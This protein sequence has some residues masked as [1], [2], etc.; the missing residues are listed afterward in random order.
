MLKRHLTH[1]V[2]IKAPAKEP[3]VAVVTVRWDLD[4]KRPALIRSYDKPTSGMDDGPVFLTW[5][6]IFE[7]PFH[8]S[9]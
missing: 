1:D 8:G 7:L 6:L 3:K 2:N 5:G 9:F 4:P